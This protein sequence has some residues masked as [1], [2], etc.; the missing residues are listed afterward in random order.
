MRSTWLSLLFLL[1][2]SAVC[3][4]PVYAFDNAEQLFTI[5][6]ESMMPQAS[7]ACTKQAFRSIRDGQYQH[8]YL[9]LGTALRQ[10]KR[11]DLSALRA[12]LGYVL[13]VEQ[14]AIKDDI[15]SAPLHGS[16]I[17]TALTYYVKSQLESNRTKQLEYISEA[18]VRL[19]S[20][21]HDGKRN[22]LLGFLYIERGLLILN[23]ETA[24]INSEQLRMAL[25]PLEIRTSELADNDARQALA[26][27]SPQQTD[28]ISQCHFLQGFILF[29]QKHYQDAIRAFTLSFQ[30]GSIDTMKNGLFMRGTSHF[31]TAQ[32]DDAKTDINAAISIYAMSGSFRAAGYSVLAM[33]ECKNDEFDR[34]LVL[35]K[36]AIQL[37]PKTANYYKIRAGIYQNLRETE[38]MSADLTVCKKLGVT[39]TE[40]DIRIT[41]K[42]DDERK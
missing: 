22:N 40:D 18:I 37:Q 11:G 6:A 1:L 19:P 20:S 4:H 14:E 36:R 35:I 2:L 29:Q 12:L 42:M 16:S 31:A 41:T 28:A 8:A 30:G 25:T 9:T 23:I 3:M 38:K 24:H 7:D 13:D 21:T 39:L 26:L 5:A 15:A 32:Y 27:L 33:V 10:K 34:A 17:A